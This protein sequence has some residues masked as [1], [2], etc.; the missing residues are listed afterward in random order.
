MEQEA[1]DFIRVELSTGL[2]MSQMALSSATP[3]K[4][5]RNR[6]NARKAYDALVRFL[7][8]LHVPPTMMVE[9]NEKLV[10]LKSRLQRLGE[11]L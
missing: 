10:E 8:R 1:I 6:A 5:E 7:P 11:E 3:A 4:R 2:L 9:F